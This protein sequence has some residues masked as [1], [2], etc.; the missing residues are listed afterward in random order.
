VPK[1]KWGYE[2]SR[3]YT[4]ST[5]SVRHHRLPNI[6]DGGQLPEVVRKLATSNT[7][8]VP[9]AKQES[10]KICTHTANIDMGDSNLYR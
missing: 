9:S 5:D 8:V 7:V 6:Q 3:M 10:T 2:A 4:T 1:P